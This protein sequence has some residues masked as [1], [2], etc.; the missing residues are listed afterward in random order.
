MI[1][2]ER[3]ARSSLLAGMMIDAAR[4]DR[5]LLTAEV[6]EELGISFR[7]SPATSTAQRRQ[8]R[9]RHLRPL[10]ELQGTSSTSIRRHTATAS[11]SRAVLPL[12]AKALAP[13]SISS[14]T[15]PPGGAGHARDKIIA[16]LGHDPS[17]EGLQITI[18]R[19]EPGSSARQRGHRDQAVLRISTT[20]R[21]R[22]S[23]R[24][25]RSSPI[26]W[27]AGPRGGTRPAATASA[28]RSA[29]SA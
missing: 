14:A 21:T 16:A 28:T 18:E 11:P 7:S 5:A 1:R 29:T 23:S 12:E 6:C 2:P 3:F 9:R 15:P 25:A 20:R 22:T 4:N 26:A 19:D 10:R 8:L 17:Q 27:P 24:P 13:R